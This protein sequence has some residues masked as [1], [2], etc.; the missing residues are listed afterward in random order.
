VNNNDQVD[1]T[2]WFNQNKK[3]EIV[4]R[5]K[6]ISRNKF[7]I[8]NLQLSDMGKYYCEACGKMKTHLRMNVKRGETIKSYVLETLF[9]AVYKKGGLIWLLLVLESFMFVY[10]LNSLLTRKSGCTCMIF[11]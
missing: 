4:G 1:A 3:I 5:V 2:L 11:F 8:T 10:S 6:V 9:S 7:N